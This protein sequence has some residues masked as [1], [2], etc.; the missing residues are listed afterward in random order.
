MGK[1]ASTEHINEEMN[2]I[3]Q[4]I[5]VL[6]T[7]TVEQKLGLDRLVAYVTLDMY[8]ANPYS[9]LGQV[10]VI[11]KK[12]DKCPQDFFDE[13]ASVQLHKYALSYKEHENPESRLKN[14][15]LRSSIVV[16]KTHAANIG[17]LSFLQAQL[18]DKKSFSIIVTDQ[19]S[20]TIDT[21]TP[22]WK[23]ALSTWE[24]DNADVMQDKNVCFV[25]VVTGFIQKNI[26]R[27]TFT[28]FQAG[29]NGGAYGLNIGGKLYTSNEEYSLDIRYGLFPAILKYPDM[30]PR[31]SGQPLKTAHLNKELFATLSKRSAA[32]RIDR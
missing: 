31:I 10:V 17:F 22:K 14:P 18:D 8:N 19:A 25:Y 1:N 15:I 2:K 30:E 16:T 20:G 7:A 28:E 21:S 12:G 5:E 4:R 26:I 9:L 23:E 3:A 6:E 32:I 13:T 27:K 24:L 11:R 29:A